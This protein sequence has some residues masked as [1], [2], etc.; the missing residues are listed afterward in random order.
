MADSAHLLHTR[1]TVV[2]HPVVDVVSTV[3]T[4]MACKWRMI[5][6]S[7]LWWLWKEQWRSDYAFGASRCNLRWKYSYPRL[8][9]YGEQCQAIHLE[10][11][12]WFTF[13]FFA[14]FL[15]G[16]VDRANIC[17]CLMRARW[18]ANFYYHPTVLEL[19]S[20]VFCVYCEFSLKLTPYMR[21]LQY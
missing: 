6:R 15:F 3:F 14:E 17:G 12:V 5:L 7:E 4:L 19:S 16:L 21:M 9:P 10:S 8:I 2:N 18:N 11:S 20:W 13:E 1:F